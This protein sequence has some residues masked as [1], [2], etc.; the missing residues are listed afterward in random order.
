MTHIL[1]KT[2]HSGASELLRCCFVLCFMV[3]NGNRSETRCL[4]LMEPRFS[5][6]FC[7]QAA[8]A[9]E[10]PASSAVPDAA[11]SLAHP[12]GPPGSLPPTGVPS[13]ASYTKRQITRSNLR[14]CSGCFHKRSSVSSPNQHFQ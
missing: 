12:A 8:P 5:H 14:F 10:N 9:W 13:A 6:Q 3:H 7:N 2:H 4:L 11:A 1:D